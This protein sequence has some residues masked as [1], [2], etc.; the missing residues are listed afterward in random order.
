MYWCSLSMHVGLCAFL[1]HVNASRRVRQEGFWQIRE[2]H[3]ICSLIMSCQEMTHVFFNH[4]IWHRTSV[5]QCT[6]TVCDNVIMCVMEFEH[7]LQRGTFKLVN[8]PPW[9]Y[10]FKNFQPDMQSA[11]NILGEWSTKRRASEGK[12]QTWGG[13]GGEGEVGGRVGFKGGAGR[14]REWQ[15]E[16]LDCCHRY[17][18][19]LLFI[20]LLHVGT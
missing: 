3:L 4:F 7:L 9:A 2:G 11:K 14:R 20:L 19:L 13:G 17:I 15:G 6:R 8:G 5:T 12:E 1:T 10:G 18:S 16:V